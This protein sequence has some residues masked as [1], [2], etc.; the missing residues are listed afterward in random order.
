M[1]LFKVKWP[2]ELDLQANNFSSKSLIGHGIYS[3]NSGF[4]LL[5]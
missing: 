5:V 1:S 2:I 3:F 4:P